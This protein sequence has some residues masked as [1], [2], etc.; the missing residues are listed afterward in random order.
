ME[1][2]DF[3]DIAHGNTGTGHRIFSSTT[4]AFEKRVADATGFTPLLASAS[5]VGQNP[6]E[7]GGEFPA[8]SGGE[9]PPESG[10]EIDRN[11]HPGSCN[12]AMLPS[13]PI[14]P[15]TIAARNNTAITGHRVNALLS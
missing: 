13:K 10:G 3:S 7:S 12:A 1:P 14:Q 2:Q 5:K 4:D 9:N 6:A 8:E 11:P 15:R